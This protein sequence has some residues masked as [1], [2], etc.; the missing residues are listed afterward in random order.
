MPL[1]P[2][3]W[4]HLPKRKGEEGR[5]APWSCR[6][7]PSPGR[8]SSPHRETQTGEKPGEGQ[9]QELEQGRGR[10]RPST[11]ATQGLSALPVRFQEY[12]AEL[13]LHHFVIFASFFDCTCGMWTFPG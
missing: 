8:K 2:Q 4:T 5:A 1:T 3:R 13:M 7:N 9:G 11:R 12:D 10:E 6:G